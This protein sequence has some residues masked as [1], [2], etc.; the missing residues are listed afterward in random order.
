MKTKIGM[1]T[2][3]KTAFNSFEMLLDFVPF[4]CPF[5]SN[6]HMYFHIVTYLI[7]AM[8]G[9]SSVAAVRYATVEE[10]MFSAYPLWRHTTVKNV[11]HVTCPFR[12]LFLDYIRRLPAQGS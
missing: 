3:Q 1:V 10:T 12:E 5:T 4:N 8:L 6:P 7:G 2:L 11:D 9:V